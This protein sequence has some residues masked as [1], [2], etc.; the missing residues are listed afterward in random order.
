MSAPYPSGGPPGHQ[1]NG[2]VWQGSLNQPW[3]WALV[4]INASD[5]WQQFLQNTLATE[6]EAYG[7]TYWAGVWTSSDAVDSFLSATPGRPSWDNFPVLCTHR[8]AWPLY[9]LTKLAGVTFDSQGLVLTPAPLPHSLLCGGSRLELSG[10]LWSFETTAVSLFAYANGSWVGRFRTAPGASLRAV[11]PMQQDACSEGIVEGRGPALQG[12]VTIKAGARS[13]GRSVGEPSSEALKVKLRSATHAESAA[14][15]SVAVSSVAEFR[16]SFPRLA[17]VDGD[18]S[19][20]E[21]A[22]SLEV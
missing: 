14:W 15:A 21:Y 19:M 9:S 17:V 7:G 8:H 22:W 13:A 20:T 18:A 2:G 6:A 1:E 11:L 4:G 10:L 5:A 3:V 12:E 16:F